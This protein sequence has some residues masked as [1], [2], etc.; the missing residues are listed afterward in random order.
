MLIFVLFNYIKINIFCEY[1]STY[2]II[3]LKVKIIF[4]F[5]TFI[6]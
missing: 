3:E 5:T 6:I 2:F 4:A 1:N